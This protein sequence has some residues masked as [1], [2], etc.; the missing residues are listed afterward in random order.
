LYKKRWDY[1]ESLDNDDAI[2]DLQQMWLH[3]DNVVFQLRNHLDLCRNHNHYRQYNIQFELVLMSEGTTLL[4]AN[5]H[6][7]HRVV[8]LDAVINTFS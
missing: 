5:Y 7:D 2:V 8:C 3:G 1:D 4:I 6:N